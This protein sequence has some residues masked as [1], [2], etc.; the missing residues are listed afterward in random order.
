[1]KTLIL[2]FFIITIILSQSVPDWIINYGKA[3]KY[4]ETSYITGFGMAIANNQQNALQQAQDIAK[5][6]LI[7]KILVN[8]QSRSQTQNYEDDNNTFSTF[9]SFTETSSNIDIEGLN[10][11]NY[12]NNNYFYSLAYIEKNKLIS[13][14]K[15][16]LSNINNIILDNI[17]KAKTLILTD[18][19]QA[20]QL[21]YNQYKYIPELEKYYN[22]L[23]ALDHQ[24]QFQIVS[25]N[26]LNSILYSFTNLPLNSFSDI[27]TQ[28]I[29]Q[30]NSQ[31]NF[32][33]NLMIS[34]IY[35]QNTQMSSKFSSL[36]VDELKNKFPQ[37]SKWIIVN[38]NSQNINYIF[39]GNYWII[40]DTIT[41]NT[42]IINTKNSSILAASSIKI[43]IKLLNKFNIEYKP[44]NFSQ[45]YIDAQ[46]FAKN[47]IIDGGIM[48][49]AW[50]SKGK[51]GLVLKNNETLEVF[52]RVNIPSY[53]RFIY[54]QADGTRVL[55]LDNYYIDQSKVNFAYKIPQEFIVSEPFGVEFLQILASTDKF[56]DVK[57][58]ND[59]IIL[60]NLP[61]FLSKTRGLKINKKNTLQTEKR[62]TITTIP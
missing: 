60:E 41:L 21:I 7:Q 53:I 19:S 33:Y 50:T 29:F 48:L 35:Y 13:T 26:Y 36:L 1:M 52:I 12:Q 6:N 34:S 20:L 39:T 44:K 11:E 25:N 4:P 2:L 15:N 10:F 22:I 55:L 59:N 31:A 32:P 49:D 62:I 45:A 43:P 28:I 27:T 54:H 8:I 24:P 16:K 51:N 61:E 57:T 23:M 47:E 42:Q 3:S 14:Y 38:E 46:E 40:N 58:N 18:K 9:Q 5:S 30:I 37:L 17:S 56:P